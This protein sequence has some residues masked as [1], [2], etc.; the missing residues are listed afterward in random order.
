VASQEAA[1]SGISV[2]AVLLTLF[3]C[4]R[5]SVMFL[6]QYIDDD[7]D[8]D[9]FKQSSSWLSETAVV[10]SFTGQTSHLTR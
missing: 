1:I 9:E 3:C 5:Y 8:D 2:L 7:D 4:T 6:S 10:V